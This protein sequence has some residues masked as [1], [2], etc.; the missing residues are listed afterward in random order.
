LRAFERPPPG[1]ETLNVA[2]EP[3]SRSSRPRIRV[4]ER[5]RRH[6]LFRGPLDTILHV[7]LYG[8]DAENGRNAMRATVMYG[9]HDVR[10]ETVPDARIVE[11][12]D[13]LVRVTRACI[14]GS[15]LWPYNSMPPAATGN[16]MGHEFIGVVE[17]IG[18]DVRT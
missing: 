11:P 2:S 13:A 12:T 10:V 6:Q 4:D 5:R 17:S 18:A 8:T 14:C 1:E 15:D 3:P 7:D 9:A 16:R